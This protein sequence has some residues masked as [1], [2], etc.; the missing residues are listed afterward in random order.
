MKY[1]VKAFVYGLRVPRH[2]FVLN[3]QHLLVSLLHISFSERWKGVY[4]VETLASLETTGAK[5]EKARLSSPTY[6]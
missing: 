3:L 6:E 5:T 2:R 1:I 4:R